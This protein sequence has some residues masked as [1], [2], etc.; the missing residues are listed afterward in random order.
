MV[1]EQQV[2]EALRPVT[3]PELNVSIV[4][5]GMVRS[6]DVRRKRVTVTVALTVAG[7]PMRD[8]VT[9]RVRDAVLPLD[10]VRDVQVDLTVMTPEELDGVRAR[11]AT[12]GRG[13]QDP[14]AWGGGGPPTATPTSTVPWGTRKVEP[15]RSAP[16][17]G[18]G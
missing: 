4:D 11:M 6:V 2:I 7:C 15:T 9:R 13:G 16:R 5:I 18:P 1:S 10:G 17:A 12:A 8:E 3:D 14:A